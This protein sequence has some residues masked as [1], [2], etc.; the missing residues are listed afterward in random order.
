VFN[1]PDNTNRPAYEKLEPANKAEYSLMLVK[2]AFA[3]CREAGA[4]QPLTA[5]V[6]L[7]PWADPAKLTPMEKACL[8]DSDVISFHVYDPLDKV[9]QCV[10]NLKR[11]NRPILCTEYMARPQGSTF[12]PVLGYFQQE[13]VAAYNWGFVDGKTQTIYPWDSWTKTYTAEPPAWFHDIFRRDGKPYSTKETD[14]IKSVTAKS[15][16]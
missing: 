1:E 4:T 14:Y 12:D 3:W 2:K 10:Q 6:W 8:E 13:G 16:R 15:K 9:K 11:Y 7:G 5:G